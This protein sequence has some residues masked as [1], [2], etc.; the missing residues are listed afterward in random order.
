MSRPPADQGTESFYQIEKVAEEYESIRFGH[1]GG[2]LKDALQKEAIREAAGA[3]DLRKK[4]VL[5]VACGT[6][7]FSRL[8]R[9]EGSRVVGID[10]SRA[11]LDQ[12]RSRDSGD[13]YVQASAFS[14]PF[15]DGTFDIAVSV[16]AFNHLPGFEEAI[17]EVCRVSHRVILG[18]PHRRSLVL[19]AYG[20]RMLRGWG[21]RYT[22]H[23]TTRYQNAPL[24]YT[25]YFTTKELEAIFRKKGFVVVGCPKRVLFPFPHVPAP[26]IGALEWMER[27]TSP[28][29]GRFG[30]FMAMVAERE[31]Q[32]R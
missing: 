31:G 29:L 18:L 8:F 12:A 1:P 6:G 5:D 30:T 17:G 21:V 16:N 22:R 20:Y 27:V 4:K 15:R 28:W 14:L 23:Q 3:V 2:R 13:A 32:D 7:R 19:L 24:I 25:R 9:S 11:M 10:L 26:L